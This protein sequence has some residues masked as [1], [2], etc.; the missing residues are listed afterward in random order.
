MAKQKVRTT[1]HDV[2]IGE[3]IREARLAKN[4]T[5]K[6]LADLIGVS[7]QQLQKY[8]HGSSRIASGRLGLLSTALNRPL[9][10]FF[11]NVT[12]IRTSGDAILNAI[13]ISKEGKL[14]RSHSPDSASRQIGDW[15]SRSHHV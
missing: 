4:M 5:Q 7:Y 6:V 12:D 13:L 15:F 3:R 2:Y 8:E 10:Y 11:A 9:V 1:Q 14:S